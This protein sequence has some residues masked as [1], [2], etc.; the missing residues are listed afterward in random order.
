MG[1]LDHLAVVLAT[2]KNP[3]GS[4]QTGATFAS[5]GTVSSS[6]PMTTSHTRLSS[7]QLWRHSGLPLYWLSQW[8]VFIAGIVFTHSVAIKPLW[9]FQKVIT[10]T[11]QN[12]RLHAYTCLY[13]EDPIQG[14]ICQPWRFKINS[15]TQLMGWRR[16]LLWRKGKQSKASVSERREAPALP[17]VCPLRGLKSSS[18][19]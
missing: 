12:S 6:L 7:L 17:S 2:V 13:K 10:G 14:S 16:R 3:S 4:L 1:S 11:K 19:C 8:S 5:Q 9:H 18:V 15:T